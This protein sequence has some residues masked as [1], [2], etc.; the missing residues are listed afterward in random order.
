MCECVHS[1]IHCH[2]NPL[3]LP[4]PQISRF[5]IQVELQVVTGADNV[6]M[7]AHQAGVMGEPVDCELLHPDLLVDRRWEGCRV[8]K[9]EGGRE[10]KEMKVVIFIHTFTH[11]LHHPPA[12]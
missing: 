9:V 12:A 10:R 7:I 3:L 4:Y 11:T 2:F 8:V 6:Q 1:F 5:S